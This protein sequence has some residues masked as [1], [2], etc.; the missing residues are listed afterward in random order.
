[1]IASDGVW[2]FFSSQQVADICFSVKSGD[3]NQTAFEIMYR[4]SRMWILE[5]GDYRDDI[6]VIV[7]KL[8]WIPA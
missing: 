7:L 3:V 2:E 1:M 8:P 6:T 4:S 5:E